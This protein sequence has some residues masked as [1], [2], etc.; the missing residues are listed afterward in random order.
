[1]TQSHRHPKWQLIGVGNPGL[2]CCALATV[3]VSWRSEARHGGQRTQAPG[4]SKRLGSQQQLGGRSFTL[5]GLV[6]GFWAE[7]KNAGG[8]WWRGEDV[9]V[10]P[11]LRKGTP[12][13]PVPT[14][15]KDPLCLFREYSETRG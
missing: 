7:D 2:R 14:G 10:A 15:S 5:E 13:D 6:R 12:K 1:M 9:E 4:T 11:T 8:D 3:P